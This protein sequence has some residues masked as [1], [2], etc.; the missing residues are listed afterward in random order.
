M[1]KKKINFHMKVNGG[2]VAHLTHVNT[3]FNAV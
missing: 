2:K 1:N 3:S